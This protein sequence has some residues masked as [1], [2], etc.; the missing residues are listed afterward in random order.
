MFPTPLMTFALGYSWLLCLLSGT[1]F[2]S[3]CFWVLVPGN[4]T[5]DPYQPVSNSCL[6]SELDFLY[7][8]WTILF[9]T[10]CCPALIIQKS[11]TLNLT[12]IPVYSTHNW[13]AFS[14]WA[15]FLISVF[16]IHLQPHSQNEPIHT[17]WSY[18]C[19][20]S[21]GYPNNRTKLELNNSVISL[22]L[23]TTCS[24]LF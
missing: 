24:L 15:Y 8:I 16:L 9:L 13:L 17:H 11:W 23:G 1:G 6:T 14:F 12:L 4:G 22:L 5:Q 20:S 18:A 7:R 3:F 10:D 19:L 21:S 2:L